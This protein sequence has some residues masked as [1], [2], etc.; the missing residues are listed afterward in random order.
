MGKRAL[1]QLKSC[2]FPCS[3]RSKGW[4]G[5]PL[6]PPPFALLRIGDSPADSRRWGMPGDKSRRA[7]GR[8]LLSRD[9]APIPQS[10]ELPGSGC[11]P[12]NPVSARQLQ[13]LT[14]GGGA[15]GGADV[16]GES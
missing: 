9:G 5:L 11:A 1:P 4:G 6:R 2:R 3:I 13:A 10:L 7:E 8:P 12:R 16:R 15:R 14:R